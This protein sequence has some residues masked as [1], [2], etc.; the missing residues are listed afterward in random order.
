MAGGELAA[1]AAAGGSA[2]VTAMATDGWEVIK[3]QFARLLGRGGRKETDA[4]IARLEEAHKSLAGLSGTVLEK[5][6]AEQEVAWRTRLA[7]LLE[8]DPS[9]ATEL[10]TLVSGIQVKVGGTADLVEQRVVAFNQARVASQGY[11]VQTNFFGD[12]GECIPD[13]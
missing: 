6:R 12:E 8:N 4:A 10:R 7:D 11:G 5:A 3:N 1:L 9:A 2:L 13:R